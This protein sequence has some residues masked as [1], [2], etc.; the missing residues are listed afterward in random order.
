[1]YM[2]CFFN[3]M[4]SKTMATIFLRFGYVDMVSQQSLGN[5]LY[6]LIPFRTLRICNKD[7]LTVG[8]N[9][10][11]QNRQSDADLMRLSC[12]CALEQQDGK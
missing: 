1:M 8:T 7:D 4:P 9:E 6:D 2:S 3:F 12:T 11:P 5:T 10:E